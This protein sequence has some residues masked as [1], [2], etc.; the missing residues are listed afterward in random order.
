MLFFEPK[1]A[2]FYANILLKYVVFDP[3]NFVFQEL[4]P[5]INRPFE[6][7]FSCTIHFSSFLKHIAKKYQGFAYF[8]A[9][10]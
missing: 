4:I 8:F 5:A 2:I 10:C 9:F 1:N 3:E 7:G 6:I